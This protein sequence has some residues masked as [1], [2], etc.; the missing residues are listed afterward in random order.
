MKKLLLLI[1][2]VLNLV[3]LQ[4]QKVEFISV[5]KAD[6]TLENITYKSLQK[7]LLKDTLTSDTLAAPA[8]W[9]VKLQKK[10]SKKQRQDS[11][12]YIFFC[13]SSQD[14]LKAFLSL[15]GK[16]G[17]VLFDSSK[18]G[19]VELER[20]QKRLSTWKYQWD[21]IHNPETILLGFMQ[22]EEEGASIKHGI[23]MIKGQDYAYIARCAYK[24]NNSEV[25]TSTQ[26]E[27][28]YIGKN[29]NGYIYGTVKVNDFIEG[30][31]IEPTELILIFSDGHLVGTCEPL[32][33]Y[34]TFCNLENPTSD[35]DFISKFED[36][37]ESCRRGKALELLQ[38]LNPHSRQYQQFELSIG[39]EV[40]SLDNNTLNVETISD[41]D[42][43]AG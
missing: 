31:R 3:L 33:D 15:S 39:G 40:Y 36:D 5:N 28:K 35:E 22:N 43:N 8:K 37:V 42:I 13:P 19:V 34:T 12:I 32:N 11:N 41:E 21:L 2:F 9:M 20:V 30:F 16:Y 23:D 6:T 29:A 38:K 18:V 27:Y 7:H 24:E 4:A 10:L 26:E 17:Y 14:S 1:L 25:G